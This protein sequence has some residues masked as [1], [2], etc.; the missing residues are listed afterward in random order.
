MFEDRTKCHADQ[1]GEGFERQTTAAAGVLKA[2]HC[3]QNYS[4]NRIVK[5]VI[6]FHAQNFTE[7]VEKLQLDLYEPPVSQCIAWVEDAKLNQLRREGIKYARVSLY[8]NDVYYLPRNIIH[9]FR[10]VT[11]VA[12]VAWHVRLKQ[13]YK[14]KHLLDGNIQYSTTK[15]HLN[16]HSP[17]KSRKSESGVPS[18]SDPKKKSVDKA[19]RK[20]EFDG[21]AEAS[22]KKVKFEETGETSDQLPI[23]TECCSP[24]MAADEGSSQASRPM[25]TDSCSQTDLPEDSHDNQPD[26]TSPASPQI[27]RQDSQT[28]EID[29]LAVGVSTAERV[30]TAENVPKADS[31]L[32]THSV[33]PTDNA[34][35]THSTQPS[36]LQSTPPTHS[37]SS[38]EPH[39]D[40]PDEQNQ[41]DEPLKSDESSEKLNG[42]T[43]QSGLSSKPAAD[44]DCSSEA[45]AAD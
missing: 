37:S 14:N 18:S 34:P 44:S 11:A 13:Y 27:S 15:S 19:K 39:K 4:T 25:Q 29:V 45:K 8:D 12:S 32:P 1:V 42:S 26:T 23:K 30:Q 36:A 24:P 16:H 10:T 28:M 17:L 9:Q 35:P 40:A 33:P 21:D 38:T 41:N 20:M 31:I 43:G 2:V 22:K 7:L 5:D 6:A 3:G